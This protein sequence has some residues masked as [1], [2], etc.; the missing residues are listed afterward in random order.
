MCKFETLHDHLDR[1]LAELGKFM[2]NAHL[3][4]QG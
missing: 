3:K 1:N 2:Q 4:S